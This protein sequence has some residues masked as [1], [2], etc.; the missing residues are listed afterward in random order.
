[1][2]TKIKIIRQGAPSRL[3]LGHLEPGDTFRFGNQQREENIYMVMY[4]GEP[5]TVKFI[6]LAT[7]SIHNSPDTKEVVRVNCVL[8]YKDV[9]EE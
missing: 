2:A 5:N 7:G 3:T 1:M 6:G 4:S 8:T 9:V